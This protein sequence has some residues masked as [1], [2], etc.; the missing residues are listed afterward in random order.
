MNES[1]NEYEF[2]IRVR[3]IAKRCYSSGITNIIVYQTIESFRVKSSRVPDIT[4]SDLLEI[5][6]SCFSHKK[7]VAKLLFF[8]VKW[9]LKYGSSKFDLIRTTHF[10]RRL[11]SPVLLS[12]YDN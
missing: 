3:G 12:L 9:S 2:M 6:H 1:M 4:D 7:N 8:S 5:L 11:I 10:L